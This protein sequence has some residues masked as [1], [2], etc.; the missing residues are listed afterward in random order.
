MAE[1]GHDGGRGEAEGYLI[2]ITLPGPD[3]RD[4]SGSRKVENVLKEF[5]IGLD[6]IR[7]DLESQEVDLHLSK[8]ELG[9]VEG[10][11]PLPL[12]SRNRQM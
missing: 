10:Q 8:L 5:I 9:N 3:I 11:P 4:I 6:T 1:G 2:N 12:I 7:G